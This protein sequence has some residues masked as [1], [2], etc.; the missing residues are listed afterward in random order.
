V[1]PANYADYIYQITEIPDVGQIP[2]LG[3]YKKWDKDRDRKKEEM[4]GRKTFSGI[5]K[6][7][8]EKEK[9]TGQTGSFFE[10]KA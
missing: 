1:G 4:K 9:E 2:G 7:E 6:K 3:S 5:L 8:R 10:A